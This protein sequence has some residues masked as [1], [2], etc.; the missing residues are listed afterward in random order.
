[1]RKIILLLCLVAGYAS[2]GI[3][4]DDGP[5]ITGSH[6]VWRNQNGWDFVLT[7]EKPNWCDGMDMIYSVSPKGNAQY[8]CWKLLNERVHIEFKGGYF[9][10]KYVFDFKNFVSK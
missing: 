4:L 6:L 10:N 5:T 9:V 3:R 1:M 7:N 8:G 2:A